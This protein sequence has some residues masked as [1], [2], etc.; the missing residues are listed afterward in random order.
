MLTVAITAWRNQ[1]SRMTD[2]PP[3]VLGTQWCNNLLTKRI[4]YFWFWG[5]DKKQQDE[6]TKQTAKSTKGQR[7]MKRENLNSILFLSDAALF[8]RSLPTARHSEL[9]SHYRCSLCY[10]HIWS[11]CG[12][13]TWAGRSTEGREKWEINNVWVSLLITALLNVVC[14]SPFFRDF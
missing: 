2:N 9:Y 8:L 14:S 11:Q 6:A 5:K 12:W 10:P 4:H 3:D 7:Y 13:K 1:N